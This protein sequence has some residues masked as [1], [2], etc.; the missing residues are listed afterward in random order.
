MVKAPAMTQMI[1]MM[2]QAR[3]LCENPITIGRAIKNSSK[4]R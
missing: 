1:V 4:K 2:S 3:Y